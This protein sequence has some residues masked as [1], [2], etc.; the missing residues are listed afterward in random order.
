M[1]GT[2]LA[3]FLEGIASAFDLAGDQ[4]CLDLPNEHQGTEEELLQ[5]DW[6]RLCSDGQRV[7]QDFATAV[8][9]VIS[10]SK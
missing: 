7:M 5:G 9:K 10:R 1:M 4:D 2:K 3:A 6:D 8:G